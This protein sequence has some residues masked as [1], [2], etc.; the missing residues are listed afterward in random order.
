LGDPTDRVDTNTTGTLGLL[1]R[2]SE[3]SLGRR[4]EYAL[5]YT[6]WIVN[7]TVNTLDRNRGTIGFGVS[8]GY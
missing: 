7:S 6:R 2:V 5:R 4:V 1:F 8:F 3:N